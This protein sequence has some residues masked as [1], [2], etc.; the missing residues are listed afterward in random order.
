MIRGAVFDADG[1]LL[2]SMWIW[3]SIAED[4]LRSL[5]IEPK[6]NL[7]ELFQSFSLKQAAEYYQTHCGVRL[8]TEEI[9]RGVDALME[10]YYREQV[11]LKPGAAGFLMK[12]REQGVKMCIATTTD[13]HLI[14]AA[15]ERC[16]VRNFF[17]EILTCAGVG[18][19]KEEPVIY[20]EAVKRLGVK[21]EE[22]LVFEDALH[23]VQTAKRDGFC[24]V[25]VYDRHEKN[26]EEVKAL[27]DFCLA[28]FEE[29]TAFWQFVYS[30]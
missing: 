15:L 17:E 9:I 2:D 29:D 21:K 10:R 8:S 3:D 26:Q 23:A 7:T 25:A 27:A 28:D 18:H 24:T 19:G 1:T 16:G 13:S 4:Y 11:A 20:R 14:K 30:I 5:N 12:L 22:T 6:E